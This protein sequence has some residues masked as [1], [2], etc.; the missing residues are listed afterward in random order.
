MQKTLPNVH[1][2]M[3]FPMSFETFQ[4]YNI[5]SQKLWSLFNVIDSAVEF[6]SLYLVW[7][8]IFLSSTPISSKNTIIQLNIS[9]TALMFRLLKY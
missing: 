4:V 6:L 2:S 5:V 1:F 8:F 3:H 9:L 7:F